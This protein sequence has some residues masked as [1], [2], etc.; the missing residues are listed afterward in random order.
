MSQTIYID[1]E[2][3][4]QFTDSRLFTTKGKMKAIMRLP[5]GLTVGALKAG[6]EGVGR[7]L[8]AMGDGR[9]Q[10]YAE[11]ELGYVEGGG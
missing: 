3:G 11:V 7:V 6:V 8:A 10:V 2:T 4:Q 5:E 1:G 9:A